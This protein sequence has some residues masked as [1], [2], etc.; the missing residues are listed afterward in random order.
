M[1]TWRVAP[2]R[3]VT[4]SINGKQVSNGLELSDSGTFRWTVQDRSAQLIDFVIATDA[5]HANGDSR[6]LGVA[7]RSVVL[8]R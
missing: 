4:V 2:G 7:L 6:S 1:T 3:R 8:S 5:F